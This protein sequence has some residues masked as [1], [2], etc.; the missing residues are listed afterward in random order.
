M[1]KPNLG[2][3]ETIKERSI[4]VYLPS[5]EMIEDWKSR[6]EKAGMS[7]SKFVI[8][9]VEDSLKREEGEEER[10][11]SRLELVKKLK[12]A[13]EGNKKLGEENRLLKKL[14]ENLDKELKRYRMKPY[15]EE[16][17]EG[18]RSFDKNLIELLRKGGSHSQEELLAHLDV[19]PADTEMIKAVSTELE[20]LEGYSLVEYS[21][22]G[23]R[24]KEKS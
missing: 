3:T 4:Y 2:K 19:D 1:P 13:G 11:L 21:G 10:Y 24:W 6:A 17:F 8:D 16:G 20:A 22:R 9:R 23:W 18:K 7:I 5:A 15:A 12:E 14:V